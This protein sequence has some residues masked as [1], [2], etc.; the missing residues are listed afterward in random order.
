MPTNNSQERGILPIPDRK[1][2]GLTTYDAKIRK[3]SFPLSHRGPPA[4]APNV[5]LIPVKVM[6]EVSGATLENVGQP[7]LR[8]R[9]AMATQ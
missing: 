5:L 9:F 8:P 3:P 6:V 1:P 4:P 7:E 2:I